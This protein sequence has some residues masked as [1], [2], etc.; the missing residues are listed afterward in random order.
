MF[1]K[2]GISLGNMRHESYFWGHESGRGMGL[3]KAQV[4]LELLSN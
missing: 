4:P 3:A 2:T 1:R